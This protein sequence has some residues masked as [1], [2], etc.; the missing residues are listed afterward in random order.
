MGVLSFGG[1][2][3]NLLST[4]ESPTGAF[5][6]IFPAASCSENMEFVSRLAF[7]LNEKDTQKG[8]LF[9]WWRWRES[10]SRPNSARQGLYECSLSLGFPS[11][12][13]GKQPFSYGRL[14]YLTEAE[15]LFRSCSPLIDA[16][17]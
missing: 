5:S 11:L 4:I 7:K 2:G 14:L 13:D 9:N 8:V 6:H 3:E 15:P 1:D 12:N 16:L 10:N 17:N